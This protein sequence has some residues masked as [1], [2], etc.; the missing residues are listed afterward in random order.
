MWVCVE[1]DAVC[2]EKKIDDETDAALAPRP[3]LHTQKNGRPR[4]ASCAQ[5][6]PVSIHTHHRQT[7]ALLPTVMPLLGR[8]PPASPFEAAAAAQEASSDGSVGPSSGGS[9]FRCVGGL[10]SMLYT[11]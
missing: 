3:L 8:T 5:G 2:G 10:W 7:T 11:V 1:R 9:C 4:R 6:L